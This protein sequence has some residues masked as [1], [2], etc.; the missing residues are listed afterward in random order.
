MLF[1]QLADQ[2]ICGNDRSEEIQFLIERL[3]LRKK[4]SSFA[5]IFVVN[6]YIYYIIGVLAS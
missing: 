4:L 1:T 6:A 2:K 3:Y 5:E